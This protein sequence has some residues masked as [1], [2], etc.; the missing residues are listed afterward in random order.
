MTTRRTL[1]A[2]L[3]AL[4]LAPAAHAQ[5][6]RDVGLYAPAPPP[7]SAFVRLLN[8]G[9]KPLAGKIGAR[10]VA[11]VPAGD[12]SAY[13]PAPAGKVAVSAGGALELVAVAGKYYTVVTGVSPLRA[14]EDPALS[15]RAKAGLTL[16]N[17]TGGP[18]VDLTTADGATVV[19]T[20]V[21][22]WALGSREVN[23]LTVGFAVRG[24]KGPL[25]T[26]P[27][28]T[29]ARGAAYAVVLRDGG[30]VTWVEARTS[31]TDK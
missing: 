5:D 17:L 30:K 1:L 20:G 10:A 22:P 3:A 13:V 29:L 24:P 8:A 23:A 16:Y 2:G 18:P 19:V 12:A 21:A 6:E 28:T 7:G 27:S 11:T 14:L 31:T 25:G 26:V 15:S 4:C 9:D